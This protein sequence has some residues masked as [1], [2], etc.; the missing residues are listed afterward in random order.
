[1]PL[2]LETHEV[3][4]NHSCF[5]QRTYSVRTDRPP[6][7][8]HYVPVMCPDCEHSSSLL[9]CLRCGSHHPP[10]QCVIFPPAVAAGRLC[11]PA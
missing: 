5:H 4:I 7:P 6:A 11:I 10:E 9:K 8:T 3:T 1:M 2:T